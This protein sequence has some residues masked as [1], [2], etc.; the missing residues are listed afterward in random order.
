[1]PIPVSLRDVVEQ[2]SFTDEQTR[3]YL[4]RDTG[5]IVSIPLEVLSLVEEGKVEPG[6]SDSDDHADQDELDELS[7]A[8]RVLE[9]DDYLALPS[10]F[11]IHEWAIMEEFCH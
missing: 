8:F 3:A 10:S 9:T 5:D 4:H 6:D 2:L 1:M 11:E 7:H